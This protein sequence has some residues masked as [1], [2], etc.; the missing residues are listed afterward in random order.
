VN[1]SIR[2]RLIYILIALGLGMAALS[3]SGFISN[4]AAVH[5]T[6]AI[7]EDRVKPLQ[8]LK[9]ISDL[10]AVNIVDT[11]HKARSGELTYA[12]AL[13]ALAEA[14]TGI[15]AHLEAYRATQMTEDESRL[16]AQVDALLPAA[17]AAV[18]RLH[19]ILEAGD[20]AGLDLFVTG[21]LYG[22]IDPLTAQI[23]QLVDLQIRVAVEAGV[24]AE[25][26][27]QLAILVM[28][29]TALAGA[30]LLVFAGYVVIRQ[31]TTPLDR[32]TSAMGRLAGGDNLIE[33][34]GEGR[35]DEIGQMAKAMAVFKANAIAKIAADA[36]AAEAKER[37]EA[38]RLAAAARAV[39]EEQQ[40]VTESFGVA[41]SKVAEGDLSWRITQVLPAAYEGLRQDF[42]MA[43]GKLSEAMRSVV[44]NAGAIQSASHEISVAADDLSRRTEQQAAGLEETAAALDQ[45]T[46]TVA[47]TAK[48]AQDAR[49]AVGAANQSARTNGAVVLQ[50]V[51]AMTAIEASARQIN[52]IIGVIDEIAFQTNLLALNAG[53]EAAR[54]GDAG[55]GFA[56]VASEVRALAQRSAD[57]AKEIKSLISASTAQVEGGVELVGRTGEALRDISDRVAQI[58]VLVAEIAS[59]A[60]EQATGL[61]Q[62]NVAVNQMDRATQQNAAMVEETTAASHSLAREATSLDELMA[63]FRIDS[64]SG[65][66]GEPMAAARTSAA[67]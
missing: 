7:I 63:Q 41:L 32:M 43:L 26:A 16:N 53:V 15:A 45:I 62:V 35:R 54:A 22:A 51:D 37:A 48:G 55:R 44:G 5:R 18:A 47:R 6:S 28:S 19:E 36:A 27:S 59:G 31:V 25:R 38:D 8:Q 11:A 30:G 2:Q 17:N 3:I 64:G 66:R 57:A 9:V 40:I 46:A 20:T 12:Q 13:T 10:Y 65:Q 42:N 21:Q 24:A 33:V 39:A 49:R 52:Q 14:E 29:V 1:L 50:A 56:V 67:A 60:E 58:D 23:S 34:P 4:T 61:N